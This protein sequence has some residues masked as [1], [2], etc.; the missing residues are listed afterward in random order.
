MRIGEWIQQGWVVTKENFGTLW[1]GTFLLNL[2]SSVVGGL[3][4]GPVV[5]GN[6]YATFR[7][8]K[9]ESLELGEI[10]SKSF[11]R[12]F[13]Y[14]LGGILLLVIW[15]LSVLCLVVPVFFVVPMLWYTFPAMV[16]RGCGLGEGMRVSKEI[17]S[18]SVGGNA[19]FLLAIIALNIVGTLACGVG[20]LVTM[21][22]TYSAIAIAYQDQAAASA[23][24]AQT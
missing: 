13:D 17:W 24:A 4:A 12:P 10:M 9:K 22:I 1:L 7:A 14:I 11:D 18:K 20:V 5:A 6:A 2:I 8:R 16:D 23:P 15:A 21:V 3:L 19:L